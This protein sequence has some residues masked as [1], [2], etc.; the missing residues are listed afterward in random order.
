MQSH[1]VNINSTNDKNVLLI[2]KNKFP[3][4]KMTYKVFIFVPLKLPWLLFYPM[5]VFCLNGLLVSICNLWMMQLSLRV[6]N[7]LLY[8]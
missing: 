7:K 5:N 8:P 6:Q 2:C 4:L 3:K 1:R